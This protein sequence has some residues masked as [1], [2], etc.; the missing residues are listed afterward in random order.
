MAATRSQRLNMVD[1]ARLAGVSVSTV[2][3]ALAG[4]PLVS[5]SLR[6]EIARLAA[7]HGYV[8]N[9]RA[10][11]LR[12]QRTNIINVIVVRP[13]ENQS[14]SQAPQIGE[15]LA[16]LS[17]ALLENGQD[18]LLSQVGGGGLRSISSLLG[19]QQADGII[20]LDLTSQMAGWEGL[21]DASSPLVLWTEMVELAPNG[22]VGV[23]HFEAGRLACEALLSR[24]CRR[25][26]FIGD[27]DHAASLENLAGFQFLAGRVHACARPTVVHHQTGKTL[28]EAQHLRL[29]H[30]DGV[31]LSRM[32]GGEFAPPIPNAAIVSIDT[33]SAS[34]RGATMANVRVDPTASARHLVDHLLRIR[35]GEAASSVVLP[36]RLSAC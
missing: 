11:A 8:V 9:E 22:M 7:H 30:A 28:S 25:L 18:I 24:G 31:V 3:R 2:S 35:S 27:E 20:A 21:D 4:S 34:P 13:D 16:N 5:Q 12:L 36:P 10:R 17:D 19:S 6:T 1:L 23:D 14:I 26:A 32:S 15:F 33:I 29:S